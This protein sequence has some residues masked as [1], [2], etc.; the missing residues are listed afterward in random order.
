[1]LWSAQE[2][3]AA[4]GGAKHASQRGSDN[5]HSSGI[6]IDSRTTNKGDLFVALKG[7]N[8][9]G[10]DFVTHAA[11]AGAQAAMVEKNIQSSIPEILVSDT[12]Q[13]LEKMA[14]TAR[15]RS[16]ARRIAITGSVGKTSTKHLIATLLCAHQSCHASVGSFNNHIGVPL[17]LARMPAATDFGV[18][19]LGM[20]HAGEIT[21]L[22]ALVAPHIAIITCIAESHIGHF[23]TLED[24][25]RAKAEI[26]DG[27]EKG[28]LEKSGPEK[29]SPEKSGIVILNADDAFLPQ[30]TDLAKAAGAQEIITV[31]KSAEATHRLI[32]IERINDGLKITASLGGDII[33]FNLGMTTTHSAWT[34][35]FGLAVAE[36][37][38]LCRQT[39][40]AALA[41][42]GDVPGR[43]RQ[44]SATLSKGR[45]IT[46]IDDS[47]NASPASMTAAIC[48]FAAPQVADKQAATKQAANK[49]AANK[50]AQS[51]RRI[52]ILADMLELGEK[53]ESL[54]LAL[55]QPLRANPPD[56]LIAFGDGM[57]VLLDEVATSSIETIA[58]ADAD[59]AL[60]RALELLRDGDVVLIK[61][62]NG[63]KA[64]QIAQ[65][66]IG[67][68]HAS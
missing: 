24:I 7:E 52:A 17:S 62:S 13:S 20:N 22:S 30:L 31:G 57:K 2:I 47:Y 43:G 12:L 14:I 40:I 46:V 1:M 10:H 59:A 42:I 19:E 39:S 66:L 60:E 6:S 25:A 35:L 33:T 55:A 15:K 68:N 28:D 38:G 61:G 11:D 44:H 50:Q 32:D 48:D 67:E 54:H 18:F 26:F 27:L 64:W 21:N 53:S 4:I 5:W 8:Y 34:A 16:N 51:P 9:N 3:N 58:C 56:M 36:V 23:A 41:N 29:S 63:M 37:E 49:Q 65:H 45:R